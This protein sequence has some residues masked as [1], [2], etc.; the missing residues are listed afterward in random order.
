MRPI[1]DGYEVMG[2]C[3][4]TV[5]AILWTPS[6]GTRWR[7]M[8]S[9]WWLM[10][11]VAS[12]IFPTWLAH[13]ATDDTWKAFKVCGKVEWVGIRDVK[14]SMK[15]A[16]FRWY[17]AVHVRVGE[18]LQDVFVFPKRECGEHCMTR[19]CI[20][21]T[22][23]QHNISD[24]AILLRGWNF[25]SDSMAI[26]TCIVTSCLLARRNS[27]AT[28]SII[29]TT[30]MCVQVRIPTPLWRA[31]FNYI[32]VSVCGVQFWTISWLVL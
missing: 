13:P 15:K 26:A 29:H 21:T 14:A 27:I 28:V 1:L 8:Y 6:Y 18:E 17:R 5:H 24:L 11:C 12:I 31:A 4:N 23:S 30:L 20:H 7:L 19:A 9:P 3:L 10:V 16:F 2:I 22:C 25:A 32:L